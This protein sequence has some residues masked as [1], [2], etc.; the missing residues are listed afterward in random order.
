MVKQ[1]LATQKKHNKNHIKGQRVRV[2]SE[3]LDQTA[4]QIWALLFKAS[5]A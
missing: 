4:L 5:L 1:Y 3:D 2:N